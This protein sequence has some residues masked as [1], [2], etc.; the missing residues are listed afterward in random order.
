MKTIQI[1]SVIAL[2]TLTQPAYS[3]GACEN[4]GLT[5]GTGCNRANG[6]ISGVI[7]D[8]GCTGASSSCV[9][10]ECMTQ[11]SLDTTE[12]TCRCSASTANCCGAGTSSVYL[13]QSTT[14][15]VLTLYEY[16]NNKNTF[17]CAP[18]VTGD[19]ACADGYYGTPTSSTNSTACSKCP[20]GGTNSLHPQ[21]HSY[22]DKSAAVAAIEN[23]TKTGCYIESGSSF[24]DS[25]GSG[26]YT[27]N[28]FYT[29]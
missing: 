29:N 21:T 11:Q 7:Y 23:K 6:G 4:L 19:Y 2:A 9:Y 13:W 16:P 27:G 22:L 18:T 1:A 26:V 3:G 12:L 24:S 20:T 28:C 8:D 10:R 15:K 14:D 5:P 25:S 17:Y